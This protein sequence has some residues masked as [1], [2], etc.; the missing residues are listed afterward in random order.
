MINGAII[1]GGFV[2]PLRAPT[3]SHWAVCSWCNGSGK[4][5]HPQDEGCITMRDYCSR[6]SATGKELQWTKNLTGSQM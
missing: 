5:T 2:T 3:P 1:A 6:C 4:R